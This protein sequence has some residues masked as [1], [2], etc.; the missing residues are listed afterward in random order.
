VLHTQTWGKGDPVVLIH[1]FTQSGASWEPL[2]RRLGANHL[3]VAVDAPGHGESADDEA[4]LWEGAARIGEAGLAAVAAAGGAGRAAVA[5]GGAGR[6]AGAAAFVGYSLGGRYALHLALSQP[7]LVSRLVLVS[8]TG[9][10]D[11]PDERAARRASDEVIAQRVERDGVP[12]FI[13]WWL[14]RPLFATLTPEAA[15]I[16]SRL[17]GRAAGWAAS[18]RRAGAGTQ[19]PLWDRLAS[20]EMPV[21]VVAGALDEAYTARAGRLVQAI[22]ANAHLAII[23]GAGHACHLE[24]P[25]AWLAVVAPFLAG[26]R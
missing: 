17:G 16:D 7:A 26:D 23:E 2:A 22:G 12:A 24:A 3:V 11:D 8:A 9:G 19:E 25:E 21:L 5:A 18:L 13:D 14:A 6:A 20:L 1:G 15:A 10:L 4:D